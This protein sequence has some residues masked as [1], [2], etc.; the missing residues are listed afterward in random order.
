MP[1]TGNFDLYY[2]IVELVFGNLLAAFFAIVFAIMI[3]G[4]ITKMSMITI[5]YIES[6]FA[7][8]YLT[9]YYGAV[10]MMVF[11]IAIVGYFGWIFYRW[12]KESAG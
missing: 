12:L 9:T 8:T 1:L 4:I 10:F 7:V 11:F 3:I 2:L 6:L 5:F